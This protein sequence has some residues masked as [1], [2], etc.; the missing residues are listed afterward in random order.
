MAKNEMKQCPECKAKVKAENL[1]KHMKTHAKES[2]KRKRDKR[3]MKREEE[4]RKVMELM[5]KKMR[6]R[7]IAVG[8]I[9]LI[10]VAIVIAF[11]LSS[12]ILVKEKKNMAPEANFRADG[13]VSV[14]YINENITFNA[15]ISK[16]ADGNI[17]N[18]TWEFGDGSTEH[19]MSVTHAYLNQ[20]EY[21]VKLTVTDDEGASSSVEKSI[22]II[23]TSNP[24]AVMKTS[25]GEF[26][27]ELYTD[28]A[29]LTANNFI[30]LARNGFYNDTRFHRVAW[31]NGEPFVIQAGKPKDQPADTIPWEKTDLKNK[32][33][34]VAMARMGNPDSEN[35]SDTASS[36]FFINLK[37]NPSLDSYKYPYVV[38]G[39]VIL[40]TDVVDAI[41]ELRDA[42][43]PNYDGEP[44]VEVRI[45][46]VIIKE[47][48]GQHPPINPPPLP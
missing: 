18:Y 48:E 21:A 28:E 31:G 29:P 35:G 36:E 7:N 1:A 23:A 13:G 5:E 40:G 15:S 34:T 41:G 22:H 32:K 27:I 11:I 33:Y 45:D 10:A 46:W 17:V 8:T 2:E 37:D 3:R 25:K 42:T 14:F 44:I 26:V 38:F 43:D 12:N 20:G 30:D 39:K 19:G 24:I 9:F 16:D 6:K 47:P 4:R